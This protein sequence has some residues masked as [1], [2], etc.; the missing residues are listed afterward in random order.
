MGYIEKDKE[1][2]KENNQ[3]FDNTPAKKKA[4]PMGSSKWEANTC[5]KRADP[6]QQR[7]IFG[8]E[9]PQ[10]QLEEE[11]HHCKAKSKLTIWITFRRIQTTQKVSV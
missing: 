9:L 1:E 5:V 11:K 3:F 10:D 8:Q 4:L 6:Y 7:N 2:D